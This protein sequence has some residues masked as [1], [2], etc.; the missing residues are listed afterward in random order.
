MTYSQHIS[1]LDQLIAVMHVAQNHAAH[2]QL[3][4]AA[5]TIDKARKELV[6][7]REA[8]RKYADEHMA[9]GQDIDG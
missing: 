5:M 8:A 9:H 2:S 6:K 7:D 4:A 1:A 3:V